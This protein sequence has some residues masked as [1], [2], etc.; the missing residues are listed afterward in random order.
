NLD[1]IMIDEK[2]LRKIKKSFERGKSIRRNLG[3]HSKLVIDQK[4]PYLC[5]YRFHKSPD[6]HIASLLKTQGAYL[7]A[8]DAMDVTDLLDTLAEIAQQDFKSFMVIELWS[9]AIESGNY[10]EFKVWHPKGKINATIEAI[11]KGFEAFKQ[12]LPRIKVSLT[13]SEHRHPPGF[14][15]L[16]TKKQ[17]QKT[18]ILLIGI[19]VPALFQDPKSKKHYPLFFRKIKR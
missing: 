1:E 5:I 7:M 13:D 8:H 17:L 3:H 18:G 4:L 16:F 19:T 10:S 11:E 15:P 6:Y 2:L 14:P 9:E 12:L